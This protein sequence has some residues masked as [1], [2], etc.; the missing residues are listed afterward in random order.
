MT[1]RRPGRR[2]IVLGLF[3]FLIAMNAVSLVVMLARPGPRDPFGLAI[4]AGR[5][6]LL[7]ALMVLYRRGWDPARHLFALC[8]SVFSAQALATGI[9]ASRMPLGL[10]VPI[11]V[12]A[13]VSD[14]RGILA[15]GLFL[16]A[17]I[18]WKAGPAALVQAPETLLVF[19]SG[20]VL[21]LLIWIVLDNARREAEAASEELRRNMPKLEFSSILLDKVGQ[22]IIAGDFDNRITYANERAMRLHGWVAEAIIGKTVPEGLIDR[23]DV[24]YAESVAAVREGRTW[25][26]ESIAHDRDGRAYPVF[27]TLSPVRTSGGEIDGWVSVSVDLTELKAAEAALAESEKRYHDLL[28][29]LPVIAFALDRDGRYT[30]SDGAALPLLGRAPG[31]VVGQSIFDVHAGTPKILA[32]LR[33]AFSGMAVRTEQELMGHVFDV[34][35]TPC[36]DED[37]RVTGVTGVSMDVTAR[38][39]A[40]NEVQRLNRELEAR[41]IER[42]AQL[43]ESNASLVSALEELRAAQTRLVLS[44][45]L[46]ALG[47]LVAG[48][49][50]QLNTPLGAM[51]SSAALMAKEL[52][53]GFL[54]FMRDYAALG[55]RE[56]VLAE[57]LFMSA[58]RI[59]SIIDPREERRRRHGIAGVFAG[60]GVEDADTLAADLAPILDEEGARR[61]LPLV[62]LPEGL[63]LLD[64]IQAV[65]TAMSAGSIIASGVEKSSRLVRTL[66]LYSGTEPEVE[67]AVRLDLREELRSLIAIYGTRYGPGIGVAFS[68]DGDCAVMGQRGELVQVFVNLLDN[69]CQAMGLHGRLSVAAV[70]RGE[71][72][73][74]SVEDTGTG[75]DE[76]I[77]MRIFEPF[78]TTRKGGEGTGLGLDIAQRIVTRHAGS[79]SF[80]SAPG[81]TVFTVDLPG[82]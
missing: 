64:S 37:G 1:L 45:K 16:L 2:E 78:F 50:H 55:P 23:T 58:S 49:A 40:E 48:I 6:F 3:L 80:E 15:S 47:Q 81:H 42:T 60:A 77:R 36:K 29:S 18:G 4:V 31:A 38:R 11:L 72:V 71:R 33:T 61:V 14:W 41:V 34:A 66:K 57:D 54:P 39:L 21:V 44:E 9:T 82:A 12:A 5:I 43:N 22:S 25:S 30:L 65:T 62:K 8:V 28:S 13:L 63:R 20:L 35:Y 32:D 76:G 70:R 53:K 10:M 69:A 74:V 19:F 56:R 52:S 68:S 79:I 51:A 46:A 73:S 24:Q 7:L 59:G 26:V 75:I 27:M 67:P 17:V